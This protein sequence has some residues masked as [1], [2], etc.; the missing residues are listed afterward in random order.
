MPKVLLPIGD[1]TET[2]DT[3][4]PIFR[5]P[6]DG[7]EVVVAGPDARLYHTVM[8]EIPPGEPKWDI[9]RESPAYHLQ[10]TAAF[11][12]IDPAEFVGLFISGG[13]RTGIHPLRQR[14]IE[15][16]S[17]LLRNR[18]AGGQCLS[19]CRDSHRRRRDRG[20]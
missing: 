1:A 18:Q 3:Y 13:L 8:H 9:T 14:L 17:P 5:L 6:E 16:H 15:D 12:D 11:R 7:F 19:R 10:A 4:Y 2:L 20:A